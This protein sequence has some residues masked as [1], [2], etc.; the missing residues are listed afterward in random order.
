MKYNMAVQPYIGLNLYFFNE[1]THQPRK[2]IFRHQIT[3]K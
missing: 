3:N 2:K 1:F